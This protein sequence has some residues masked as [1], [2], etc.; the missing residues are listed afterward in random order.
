MFKA[1]I[2]SNNFYIVKKSCNV[3]LNNYN[4][5]QLIGIV[6]NHDELIEVCNNSK[7]DMIIISDDNMNDIKF[8]YLLKNIKIK[9]VFHKNNQ[10]YKNSK[11]QLYLPINSN[12]TYLVNQ[13][14]NFISKLYI[15]NIRNEVF[16]ILENLNFDFK[17]IGTNYLLDAIVYSYQHKNDYRFENL[18]K[19][20]YPYVAKLHKAS[21]EN[22]K[23][24]IIRSVNNMNAHI[25]SNNSH[26]YYINFCDRATPKLII[27]EIVNR[28]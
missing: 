11:Y 2:F 16:S 17:L 5:I 28:L 15:K 21:I 24:S 10:N 27:S 26:K 6:G 19:R 7:I 8:Q 13:F 23:F 14:K 25:N 18:E 20:I 3:L 4:N 1:V 12:D 9:V 22:I